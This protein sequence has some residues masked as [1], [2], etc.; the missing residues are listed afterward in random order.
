MGT[1][2]SGP[3][4]LVPI[5]ILAGSNGQGPN[6][7]IKLLDFQFSVGTRWQRAQ[8]GPALGWVDTEGPHELVVSAERIPRVSG[9]LGTCVETYARGRLAIALGGAAAG[10]SPL[11]E[12]SFFEERGLTIGTIRGFLVDGYVMIAVIGR[13]VADSDW[14]LLSL[15]VFRN[16]PIDPDEA[17]H[18][19]FRELV[20]GV[21]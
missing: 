19:L 2:T 1:R 14:A 16:S 8:S 5:T 10:T 13:L 7:V 4:V 11:G 18:R 6:N 21:S 12:R 20:A 9:E 17:G 3:E 15:V